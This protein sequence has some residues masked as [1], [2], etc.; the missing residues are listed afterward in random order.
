MTIYLDDEPFHFVGGD[1]GT[2]LDAANRRV[3]TEGRVIVEVKVGERTL[4]GETLRA[5]REEN[6]SGQEVQLISADPSELAL[7]TLR[8]VRQLLTEAKEGFGAA[9]QAFQTDD[10]AGGMSKLGK[11][12]DI[13]HQLPTAILHSAGLLNIN[14]DEMPAE[15]SLN[16]ASHEL[17]DRLRQLRESVQANDTVTL[18]DA[19]TYEWPKVAELWDRILIA[20]INRIELRT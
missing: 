15:L 11:A 19:L 14:L 10:G 8:Q 17:A 5:A 1:L 7:T 3:K 4:V 6:V 13:W 18:A 16:A 2:V 12:M 9:A 20:L